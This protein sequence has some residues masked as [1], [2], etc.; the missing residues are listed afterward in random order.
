MEYGVS[1]L[2]ICYLAM[3]WKGILSNI[4]CIRMAKVTFMTTHFFSGLFA[5][6]ICLH[7]KEIAVG[8]TVVRITHPYLRKLLENVLFSKEKPNPT[9]L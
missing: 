1:S 3:F 5:A 8:G 6:L 4:A 9:T 7:I 2:G